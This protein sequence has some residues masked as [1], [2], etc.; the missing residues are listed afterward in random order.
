MI[1]TRVQ[2]A[3]AAALTMAMT[4][5]LPAQRKAAAPAAAPA[6][7]TAAA[8]SADRKVPFRPG[9]TLT[10][11]VS[12]SN[13]LTAGVA[14]LTVRDKRPSG[15]S[16]A[17]YIVAEGKPTGLV[18]SLY[19]LYYKADTLLDS[20]SLLPERGSIYSQEGS[21]QRTRTT[22]FDHAAQRADYE[23]KTGTTVRSTVPLPKYAQD[24]L[25]S[26]YALRAVP[27]RE[28]ARLSMP[29]CDGGKVYRVQFAIGGIESV[30]AP[31]G[32]TPAYRITLS[33]ADA[34]GRAAGRP[35]TLWVSADER[36]VPLKL[37]ADLA[38]GSITM[39]LRQMAP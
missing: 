5:G 34:A 28:N 3:V 11:D 37:Q 27:L 21:R 36:R 9:E 7:P 17:Y 32:R 38:V 14:T 33:I 25:S 13:Y 31:A 8:P 1:V 4:A 39:T 6:A 29:V 19:T 2:A 15:Q 30:Q 35:I 23:F 22:R 10:Y 24:A 12:W 18:S 20:R 16:S 26:I